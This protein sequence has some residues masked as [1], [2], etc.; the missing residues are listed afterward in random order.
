MKT[1]DLSKAPYPSP[2]EEDCCPTFWDGFLYFFGLVENPHRRA[3]EMFRRR[4]ERHWA[5]IKERL[6]PLTD[7]EA[8]QIDQKNLQ[9]DWE[10]VGGYL[11]KAM[12]RELG[13]E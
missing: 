8:M 5:D 1:K 4:N 10:R 7:E 11:E 3:K 9:G 12:K 2:D 13:K 6:K